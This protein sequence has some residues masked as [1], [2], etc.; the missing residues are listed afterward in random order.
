MMFNIFFIFFNIIATAKIMHIFKYDKLNRTIFKIGT[1]KLRL[2]PIAFYLIEEGFAADVEGFVR[3]RA[4]ESSKNSRYANQW[5]RRFR[6]LYIMY[7][8]RR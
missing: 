8:L 7:A 6:C 5:Q 4:V 1:I 2:Q 3:E